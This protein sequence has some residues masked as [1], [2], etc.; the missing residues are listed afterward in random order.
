[1]CMYFAHAELSIIQ[2][3]VIAKKLDVNTLA[4]QYFKQVPEDSLHFLE[5]QYSLS[6]FYW[7]LFS[8]S[9]TKP[10]SLRYLTLHWTQ[11]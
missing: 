2:K 5:A 6:L 9:V 7:L 8:S 3:R 1:M 10:S 11:I 4:Q